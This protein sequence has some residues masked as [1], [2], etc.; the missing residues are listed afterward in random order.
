MK[1]FENITFVIEKKE[2]TSCY[3]QK[4]SKKKSGLTR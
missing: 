3:I 2:G 1:Q 4:I